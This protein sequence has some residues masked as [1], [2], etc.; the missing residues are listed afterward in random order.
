[1]ARCF[2]A[3]QLEHSVEEEPLYWPVRQ[4]VHAEDSTPVAE[5]VRIFPAAHEV[6]DSE[7]DPLY[8][9]EAQ[10]QGEIKS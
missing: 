5:S 7:A 6:Q 4:A 9:P 8:F 2:P 1:M 3:S 10:L